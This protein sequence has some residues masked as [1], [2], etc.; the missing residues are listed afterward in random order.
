MNMNDI[1]SMKEKR[2]HKEAISCLERDLVIAV[3]FFEPTDLR[4]KKLREPLE[5][6]RAWTA[7]IRIA[8]FNIMSHIFLMCCESERSA[9]LVLAAVCRRWRQTILAIPLTW[10]RKFLY[11]WANNIKPPPAYIAIFLQRS[12]PSYI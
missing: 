8:P 6:R 5:Q 10:S 7:P 2:E 11:T 4:I 1:L 3:V 9:P 12:N